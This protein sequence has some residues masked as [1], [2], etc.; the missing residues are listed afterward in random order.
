VEN[1]HCRNVSITE[2]G[3][4]VNHYPLR[5]AAFSAMQ[6][7]LNEIYINGHS[8]AL[9]KQ[10]CSFAESEAIVDTRSYLQA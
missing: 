10:M 9:A 6:Q 5:F 8:A 7:I 2:N 4:Q 3:L 1:G